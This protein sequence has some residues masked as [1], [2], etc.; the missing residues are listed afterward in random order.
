[1]S[2]YKGAIVNP[3]SAAEVVDVFNVGLFCLRGDRKRVAKGARSYE[4]CC[5]LIPA[6]DAGLPDTAESRFNIWTI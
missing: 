5:L 4:H 2:P 6:R 1:M 3:L